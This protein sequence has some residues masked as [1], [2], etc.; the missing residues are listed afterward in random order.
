MNFVNA[1]LAA[2]S[3]SALFGSSQGTYISA[4]K[5]PG[6]LTPG[7]AAGLEDSRNGFIK[8]LVK[9]N[10]TKWTQT[11]EGIP[12]YGSVLTTHNDELGYIQQVQGFVSQ[13]ATLVDTNPIVD[14]RTAFDSVKKKWN[15]SLSESLLTFDMKQAVLQILTSD[16]GWDKLIW[17]IDYKVDWKNHVQKEKESG[18]IPASIIALVNAH[19]G[20]IE[21]TWNNIQFHKIP[22]II[23]NENIGRDFVTIDVKKESSSSDYCVHRDDERRIEVY[24]IW[25]RRQISSATTSKFVCDKADEAGWDLLSWTGAYS[26]RNEAFLHATQFVDLWRDLM[27]NV[28]E[29]HETS[30]SYLRFYVH[31]DHQY[32]NAFFDGDSFKFGDGKSVF[33]PLTS[34]DIVCHEV[35]HA[36]TSWHGGAMEYHKQS[37]GMNE[38]YSD[39]LGETCDIHYKNRH[40]GLL[41]TDI[42]RPGNYLGKAMRSMCDPPSIGNAAGHL[43]DYN[44]KMGVH[45]SSGIYNKAWCTLKNSENWDYKMAFEIF[46]DAN[47][48]YWNPTSTMHCGACG[49]ESAA[50]DR[51]YN[52]HDVTA[53]FQVVGVSCG[54]CRSN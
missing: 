43:N 39:I 26:P 8:V 50:A 24:D 41:A 51:G 49:V 7:A 2:L 15:H 23:G 28:V 53:A 1:L 45:S 31:Y 42:M 29:P 34:L 36:I 22:A 20:D 21:R 30:S 40:D 33:Y 27:D 13:T 19:T 18:P 38:A 11:I 37:G 10:V 14:E 48:F 32:E 52:V 17:K 3:L 5:V 16:D 35:G 6:L 46:T 44:D 54:K 47:L 9:K 4:K 12:V 25:N